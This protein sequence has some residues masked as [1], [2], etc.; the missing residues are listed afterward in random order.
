MTCCRE[1]RPKYKV[2]VLVS[3]FAALV[4]TPRPGQAFGGELAL[5]NRES[6]RCG[7]SLPQKDCQCDMRMPSAY[8]R[9]GSYL[10]EISSSWER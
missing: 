3:G 6:L 9:L 8:H 2:L 7:Q 5:L 1:M 4:S 10:A